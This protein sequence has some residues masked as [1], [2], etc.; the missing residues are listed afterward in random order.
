MRIFFLIV[1]L[2]CVGWQGEM[3]LSGESVILTGALTLWYCAS[4]ALFAWAVRRSY[5]E[6][7]AEAAIEIES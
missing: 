2:A 4:F 6:E 7:E 5:Q 3:L 1:L